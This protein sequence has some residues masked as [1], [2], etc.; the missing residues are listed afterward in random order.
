MNIST[1]TLADVA[2]GHITEDDAAKLPQLQGHVALA[3]G[4]VTTF[5]SNFFH[6]DKE[7]VLVAPTGS[8]LAVDAT[9]EVFEELF[10]GWERDGMSESFLSIMRA[11]HEQGIEYIRF[12]ADARTIPDAKIYDW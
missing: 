6:G 2:M 1:F 3:A 9:P 4:P 8:F 12:D 7:A 5:G 11:C 10:K